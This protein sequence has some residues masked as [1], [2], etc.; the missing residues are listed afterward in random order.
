[1]IRQPSTKILACEKKATTTNTTL[2]SQRISQR[3][4]LLQSG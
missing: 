3:A 2:T 4:S 1:M